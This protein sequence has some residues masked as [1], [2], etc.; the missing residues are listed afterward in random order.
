MKNKQ[1]GK[2][3]FRC[4]VVKMIEIHKTSS[5]LSRYSDNTQTILTYYLI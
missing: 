2:W 1:D 4:E 5:K 3:T